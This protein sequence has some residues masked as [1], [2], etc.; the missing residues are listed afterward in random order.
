[1]IFQTAMADGVNDVAF[2]SFRNSLTGTS[3]VSIAAGAP[4]ILETATASA[5]GFYGGVALTSTSVVN[6]LYIGNA[7]A[8]VGADKV[9]L[10]QCYG[11]DTDAIVATAGASVGAQLI[12]N[13]GTLVTVGASTAGNCG[14]QG[15]GSGA[16]T[17]LVAPSGATQAATSV[18]VRAL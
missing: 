2:R 8:A 12:P 9:G 3:T 13:V 4:V 10:V 6:N 1:M 5:N 17:V 16:L 18:F 14:L 7:H 15:G 11:V